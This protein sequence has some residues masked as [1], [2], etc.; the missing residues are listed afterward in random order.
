M[1]GIPV[2][3]CI[4]NNE[5]ST[6]GL[7]LLA[8]QREFVSVQVR[9][10]QSEIQ[11]TQNNA[12][13]KELLEINVHFD[14]LATASKEICTQCLV[15][16]GYPEIQ[17]GV[18]GSVGTYIRMMK[19]AKEGFTKRKEQLSKLMISCDQADPQLKLKCT[20]HVTVMQRFLKTDTIDKVLENLESAISKYDYRQ[21]LEIGKSLKDLQEEMKKYQEETQNLPM[22]L[23]FLNSV[24]QFEVVS[25]TQII[26]ISN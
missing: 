14:K 26:A 23:S 11:K 3:R 13:L 16:N 10:L 7:E 9:N 5:P 8:V 21:I 18:L 22:E 20:N 1:S 17:H 2:V 6:S 12:I 25:E 19:T 24:E 4:A 15:S